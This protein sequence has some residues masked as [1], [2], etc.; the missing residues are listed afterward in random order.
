MMIR[1][2]HEA[3]LFVRCF[4][5]IS[6]CFAPIE[7]AQLVT[8]LVRARSQMRIA[9]VCQSHKSLPVKEGLRAS[10]TA[11]QQKNV[12]RAAIRERQLQTVRNVMP[13]TSGGIAPVSLPTRTSVLM[14]R[15][16]KNCAS[17]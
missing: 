13:M 3:R 4:A 8:S 16:S 1:F 7:G 14:A 15:S 10:F 6:A 2:A 5:V 12:I 17:S 9:R 11:G